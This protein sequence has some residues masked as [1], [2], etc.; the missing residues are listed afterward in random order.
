MRYLLEDGSG[1]VVATTPADV[2]AQLKAGG[3]FTEGQPDQVYMDQFAGRFVEFY[4]GQPPRT[5][6]PDNFVADL[7]A[8][9]WLT[10]VPE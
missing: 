10:E 6:T 7:I 4:G 9:G 2:V 1:V 8:Q 5:D 3:R